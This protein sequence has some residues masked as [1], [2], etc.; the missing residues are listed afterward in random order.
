[1]V[2]PRFGNFYAKLFSRPRL[3]FVSLEPFRWPSRTPPLFCL[4]PEVSN[5]VR[6][7]LHLQ[8]ADLPKWELPFRFERK[9]ETTL[10]YFCFLRDALHS[11][12]VLW[13]ILGIYD[14]CCR[15]HQQKV[16]TSIGSLEISMITRNRYL[17][18]RRLP[19]TKHFSSVQCFTSRPKLIFLFC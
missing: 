2:W 1:M 9:I 8:T 12:F 6:G 16:Q 19:P 3:D 7:G 10:I 17:W 11:N 5:A 13:K 4:P 15:L 14:S 18:G